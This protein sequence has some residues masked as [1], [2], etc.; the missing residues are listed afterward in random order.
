MAAFIFR[1]N[2]SQLC[3]GDEHENQTRPEGDTPQF[4]AE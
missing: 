2:T 4:T 3:C 1:E